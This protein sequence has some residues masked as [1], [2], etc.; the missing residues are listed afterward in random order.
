MYYKELQQLKSEPFKDSS[1]GALRSP[2][3][4]KELLEEFLISRHGSLEVASFERLPGG[5]GKQTFLS[6][7][8]YPKGNVDEIVVRKSDTAPF[9][10]HKGF[11]LQREYD[12]LLSLKKV[13][14]PAPEPIDLATQ[15]PGVEMEFL[16]MKKIPGQ[17]LSPFFDSFG[18]SFGESIWLQ[19]AEKLAMLH[20]IPLETFTDHLQ[21]FEPSHS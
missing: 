9:I 20:A 7:I 15:L 4:S 2:P 13:D 17:I 10:I 18:R 16:T 8:K 14:F 19:L 1:V 11:Q 21:K 6:T 5:F 3:L 12:L